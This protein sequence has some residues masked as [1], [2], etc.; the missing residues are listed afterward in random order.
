VNQLSEIELKTT[1]ISALQRI[2]RKAWP[3]DHK[4]TREFLTGNDIQFIQTKPEHYS[5]LWKPAW[6]KEEYNSCDCAKCIAIRSLNDAEQI[7]T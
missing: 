4:T 7:T 2:A 5:P 1:L 6:A 3:S